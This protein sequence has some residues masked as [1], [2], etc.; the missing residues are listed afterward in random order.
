VRLGVN[1]LFL[2]PGAVGG[3][4]TYLRET[5]RALAE[6]RPDWEIVLFT[7]DENEPVF[8]SPASPVPLAA[9]RPLGFRASWRPRRIVREQFQLPRAARAAA[10]DVLWSPGYTAPLRALCPQAVTIHDTQY[11][12]YPEDLSL[13]HRLAT[14]A[15]VRGACRAASRILAVSEF[16]R[17]EIEAL[18]PAAAPKIVVTPEAASPAFARPPDPARAAAMRAR[19]GF[20]GPYIL[21]VAHTYPHKNVATLVRAFALV[22]DAVPHRLVLVGHPR[23]GEPEVRRARDELARPDRVTRLAGL[24]ADDL[25]ALYHGAAVFAFPS[26]YEGFGLPVLEALSAGAPVLAA[27]RGAVPEVGGEAVDYVD[28]PTPEGFA[29]GLRRLAAETPDRRAARAARGRDRAA[30]FTWRATAE[31]TARAIESAAR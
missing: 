8:A 11:R 22:A 15:L 5:L 19:L 23:R 1:T 4:E 30:R 9:R 28:P 27:R 18:A 25:S 6:V 17:R 26:L 2:I 31:A 29:D 14:D 12:R 10:I 13:S 3:S 16:T 24:E 20:D 21:C 7:N